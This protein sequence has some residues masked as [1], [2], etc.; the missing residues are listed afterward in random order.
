MSFPVAATSFRVPQSGGQGGVPQS[1]SQAEV[2]QSGSQSGG[3]QSGSS[4]EGEKKAPYVQYEV[5]PGFTIRMRHNIDPAMDP[6]KLKRVIANRVSAQKSRW[7]KLLYVE[8][9]VKKSM[10]LE[11]ETSVLRAQLEIAI[12]EKRRLQIE[13]RQLKETLAARFQDCIDEKGI[14]EFY[15]VEIERLKKKNMAPPTNPT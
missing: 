6:K 5:E 9:L 7:K 3:S 15:K 4:Q 8:A 1:G 14:I 11:R 12:Q 2:S 13:Q 10:E